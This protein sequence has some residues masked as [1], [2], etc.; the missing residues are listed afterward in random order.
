MPRHSRVD[1]SPITASQS[2]F[3]AS[4]LRRC[5]TI[6]LR[7]STTLIITILVSGFAKEIRRRRRRRSAEQALRRSLPAPD[8]RHR[9]TVEWRSTRS[10]QCFPRR[11]PGWTQSPATRLFLVM[12]PSWRPNGLHI[13]LYFTKNTVTQKYNKLNKNK[14]I[15]SQFTSAM[16]VIHCVPKSSTPNSWR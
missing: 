4:A 11:P 1:E 13:Q 5:W 2:V 15:K 8:G 16:S 12:S 3:Q 6:R 7:R 9:A 14:W 10:T